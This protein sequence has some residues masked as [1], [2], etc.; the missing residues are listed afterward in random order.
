M[1]GVASNHS[2]KSERE[3]NHHQEKFSPGEP[4]FSLTIPFDG[5]YIDQS[6]VTASG[7]KN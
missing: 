4:E 2:N 3:D 1:L 7:R 6:S 5:C